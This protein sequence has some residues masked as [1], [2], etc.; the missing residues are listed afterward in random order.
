MKRTFKFALGILIIGYFFTGCEKVT[1]P[2]NPIDQ[3]N[4]NLEKTI[5][6][7]YDLKS[8]NPLSESYGS[9]LIRS[10]GSSDF[11]FVLRAYNLKPEIEY[12]VLATPLP[13]EYVYPYV[14]KDEPTDI[15]NQRG[16]IN[17]RGELNI[18]SGEYIYL[19]F[20]DDGRPVITLITEKELF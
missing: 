14:I 6:L 15:A 18:K 7:S 17:I 2:K 5:V 20:V 4:D 19:I 9:I 8:P 11:S 10:T 12:A 16:M 3:N 1:D 13:I